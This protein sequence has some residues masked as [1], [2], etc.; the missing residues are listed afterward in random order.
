VFAY[1]D[2]SLLIATR[3]VKATRPFVAIGIAGERD[4]A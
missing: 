1:Q 3:A 4:C 2:H